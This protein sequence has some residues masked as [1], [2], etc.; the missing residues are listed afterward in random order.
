M[1]HCVKLSG[2]HLILKFTFLFHT[3]NKLSLKNIKKSL[4][5]ILHIYTFDAKKI[6]ASNT[7]NLEENKFRMSLKNSPPTVV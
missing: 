4:V 6:S 5:F 7:L 2:G 3:N 1:K